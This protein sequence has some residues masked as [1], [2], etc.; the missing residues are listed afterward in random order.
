M[1]SK[2]QNQLLAR[3]N[4]PLYTVH[5]LTERHILVAGGGG[6][7]KT[8][9]PNVIQIYELI[10]SGTTCR[11]E[12]VTHFETGSEAIMNCTVFDAGKYFLLFAGM[13]GNCHVYKIKH[14]ISDEGIEIKKKEPE[15]QNQVIQRKNKTIPNKKCSDDQS[16][17]DLNC[18]K[19]D[20]NANVIHSRLCFDIKHLE[21]FQTDFSAELY[22]KQ[23]RFS[24]SASLLATAGADGHIRIWKH[25]KLNKVYDIEAHEADVG[26]LD[27]CPLGKRMVS[28][29]RDG[30]GKVWSLENGSLILELKYIL[31]TKSSAKYTFRNCRFGIVEDKNDLALFATLN[32]VPSKP[33]SQCYIAKWDTKNFDQQKIVAAGTDLFSAMAISDNGHFIGL[34]TQSGSVKIYIAFS[35]QQIY[36]IDKVHGIFVTGLEFL[37][38]RDESRRITGGHET[39]LLSISIDNHVIIHH[40]PMRPSMGILTLITLFILTLFIIFVLMDYLNL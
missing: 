12:S 1:F 21:S 29:S 18:K 17:P 25:P 11:A 24:N 6:S 40:I 23:V 10:N 39:S 19:P 36:N 20:A 34:G 35:L 27:I 2:K 30:R 8:G 28:V 3:V 9:I 31:P 14:S 22:Q 26:D 33:S 32:P 15:K 37:P 4:F 5:C 7:A 16:S 38:T 13:E